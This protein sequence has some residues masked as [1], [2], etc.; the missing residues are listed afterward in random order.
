LLQN[1]AAQSFKNHDGALRNRE[2]YNFSGLAAANQCQIEIEFI[3]VPHGTQRHMD[4]KRDLKPPL[5][6]PCYS[7]LAAAIAA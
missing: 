6:P 7:R 4:S 5:L 2:I 3:C 1:Q